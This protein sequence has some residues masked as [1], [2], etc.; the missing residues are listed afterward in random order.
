MH[1]GYNCLNNTLHNPPSNNTQHELAPQHLNARYNPS[2][3]NITQPNQT[4]HPLN[5]VY[6]A[7]LNDTPQPSLRTLN[8]H[9]ANTPPPTTG[10]R[11]QHEDL[12][13]DMNAMRRRI[14]IE[15]SPQAQAGS[16]FSMLPL[17]A[18]DPF[19]GFYKII[20]ECCVEV[21]N[22]QNIGSKQKEQL[23]P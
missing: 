9:F 2:P 4:T 19:P 7:S 23:S 6:T 11:I 3:R 13:Q 10:A 15:G 21:G 18:L 17:D 16:F 5:N 14:E 20:P 8:T 12:H 22:D 1:G